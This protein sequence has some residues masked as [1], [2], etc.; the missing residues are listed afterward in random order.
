MGCAA[1]ARWGPSSVSG[2][3]SSLSKEDQEAKEFDH[4]Q[5]K[6]CKLHIGGNIVGLNQPFGA[7]ATGHC[8]LRTTRGTVLPWTSVQAEV[9]ARRKTCRG[10]QSV[11]ATGT[12]RG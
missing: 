10:L 9:G 1:E 5:N 11:P 12:Q 6:I 4:Q 3:H 7:P 2:G 8:S